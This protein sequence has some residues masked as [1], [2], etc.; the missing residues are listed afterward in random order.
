MLECLSTWA[1]V[2]GLTLLVAY[3]IGTWTHDH[4]SKPNVPSIKPIPFL[5]NMAPVVFRAQSFPDF[6]VY[7]YN[8]FKG[9][10]YGGMYQVM[11]PIVLLRDPELIKMVTVKDFEHFLDRQFLISENVEPLLGKALFNLKGEQFTACTVPLLPL[12]R[13]NRCFQNTV[14]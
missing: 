11:N 4:F 8:K 13:F 5:G 10:K 7:M 14:A 12:N 6:V 9:H 3:L 2:T 1:L